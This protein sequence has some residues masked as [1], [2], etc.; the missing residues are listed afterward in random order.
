MT[1]LEYLLTTLS[2]ECAETAQR[3][4]KAIRFGISEIQ[5]G[6]NED[7]KRRLEREYAEIVAVGDLLGLQI[8]E[9]DKAAKHEKL[10]KF[11][12]YSRQIGT[13]EKE[14]CID[15]GEKHLP[16]ENPFCNK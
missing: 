1:E 12:D 10:K 9:E 5:P 8:R 2:E 14:K 16:H 11:M 15:C 4:S 13:L 6:Q 7:N 3:A